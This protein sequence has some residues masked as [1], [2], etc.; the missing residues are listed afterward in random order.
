MSRSCLLIGFI[1][2]TLSPTQADETEDLLRY[3]E[4]FD[5]EKIEKSIKSFL[6]AKTV[7][8]KIRYVRDPKRVGPLMKAYYGKVAYQPE[9]FEG[10]NK[11]QVSYR[12]RIAI[13]GVTT[14]DFLDY[15]INVR[16]TFKNGNETYPVDWESWVGYGEKTPEEMKKEKPA[17]PFLVRAFIEKS[18]YYNYEF[19]DDTK[20]KSMKVLIGNS[21]EPFT[22]YLPRD[23][24]LLHKLRP[25][26]DSSI[27]VILKVAY[28]KNA[29]SDGQI[30]ITEVISSNSWML[31]PEEKAPST[32]GKKDKPL[33]R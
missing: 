11:N 27:K 16:S 3:Y 18:N 24:N 23:S 10:L 29:R 2:S 1:F 13:L 4:T 14:G 22:G 32:P 26:D 19:T 5:H 33:H 7:E 8:E 30:L 21:R 20:W 17:T 25:D 31:E 15:T 28:P 6:T 12:D 9:G